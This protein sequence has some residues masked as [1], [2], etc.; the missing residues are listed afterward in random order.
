MLLKFD[1]ID[2]FKFTEFKYLYWGSFFLNLGIRMTS[3]MLAWWIYKITHDPLYI[4]FIAMAEVIP[5]IGFAIFAGHLVDIK[6]KTKILK[7]CCKGFIFLYPCFLALIL[8]FYHQKIYFDWA[9]WITLILVFISGF[10]RAFSGPT[11][12]SLITYIIPKQ[13]LPKA[14]SWHKG[15]FFSSMVFGHILIGFLIYFID[16]YGAL[17]VICCFI[18]FRRYFFIQN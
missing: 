1:S 11:L 4:G 12:Q 5:A 18:F 16:Y 3:T 14:V 6:E 2:V 17:I 7:N 9:I 13:L 8:L 10:I 15:Q